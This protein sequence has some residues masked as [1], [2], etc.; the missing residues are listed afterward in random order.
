LKCNEGQAIG[1]LAVAEPIG[2]V[3]AGHRQQDFR[4]QRQ[5]QL[6]RLVLVETPFDADIDV[7]P[8]ARAAGLVGRADEGVQIAGNASGIGHAEY[9]RGVGHTRR[10][11]AAYMVISDFKLVAAHAL[12]VGALGAGIVG[13]QGMEG[14]GR[15]RQGQDRGQHGVTGEVR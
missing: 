2:L 6:A 15:K 3:G 1:G 5:A 12:G 7:A 9:A 8:A 13:D 4:L 14:Q 10:I 11:L